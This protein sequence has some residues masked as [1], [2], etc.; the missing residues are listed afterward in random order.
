LAFG[1]E[2]TPGVAAS[3]D[4]MRSLGGSEFGTTFFV[5]ERTGASKHHIRTRRTSVNWTP[6]SLA[7]RLVLIS[8]SISNVVGALRCGLGVEPTSVQ[9][10]RPDPHAAFEAVWERDP[11][12][13]SSG[14]DTLLRIDPSDELTKDELLEILEQRGHL[15]RGSVDPDPNSA[16]GGHVEA[17]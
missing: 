2:E 17:L 5:A 9:F 14:M 10:S 8:M 12:V 11:S 13:R 15:S 6:W 1:T 16:G 7:Q 4:A 3:A